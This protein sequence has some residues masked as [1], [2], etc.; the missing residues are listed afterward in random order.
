MSELYVGVITLVVGIV[1][2]VVVT[3][4]HRRRW[5]RFNKEM[6]RRRRGP[7]VLDPT[8]G[9]VIGQHLESLEHTRRSRHQMQ[10]NR[11]ARVPDVP[12]LVVDFNVP[13][14]PSKQSSDLSS[15]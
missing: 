2:S 15:S 1:A 11:R 4:V 5:T 13:Y 10:K 8:I 7:L 6:Q 9:R 3:V 14:T 12:A